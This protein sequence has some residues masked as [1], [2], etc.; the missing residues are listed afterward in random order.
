MAC[1]IYYFREEVS[2][3]GELKGY[4]APCNIYYIRFIAVTGYSPG[5]FQSFQVIVSGYGCLLEF[6]LKNLLGVG[7]RVFV[8]YWLR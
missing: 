4:S 1:N 7:C 3:G 5:G 2:A 6:V 8:F